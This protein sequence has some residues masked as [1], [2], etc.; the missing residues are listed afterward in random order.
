MTEAREAAAWF[1]YEAE[2]G[3]VSVMKSSTD[4]PVFLFTDPQF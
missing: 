2:H 4:G 1:R 3:S